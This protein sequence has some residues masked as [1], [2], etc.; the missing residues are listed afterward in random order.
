MLEIEHAQPHH[1][2]SFT[3]LL[4]TF[5]TL[6]KCNL[7]CQTACYAQGQAV[8]S[9]CQALFNSFT[10]RAETRGFGHLGMRA[11]V[12][13]P[14][15]QLLPMPQ[16]VKQNLLFTVADF[17]ALASVSTKLMCRGFA[18]TWRHTFRHACVHPPGQPAHTAQRGPLP[19]AAS[20]QHAR[21]LC[22]HLHRQTCQ[23]WS[24]W[25]T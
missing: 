8:N 9:P 21:L 24:S 25:P 22:T 13:Q 4:I 19:G 1:A 6:A 7:A 10:R 12:T 18:D 5:C 14:T 16:G 23:P 3:C 2:L 17:V 15:P 11:S 20:R